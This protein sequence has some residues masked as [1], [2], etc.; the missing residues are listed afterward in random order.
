MRP[1]VGSNVERDAD[2][3]FVLA[4]ALH[5][6]LLNRERVGADFNDLGVEFLELIVVC[7][8]PAHLVQSAACEAGRV[9]SN[10]NFLSSQL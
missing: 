5:P 6:R 7:A 9:E 4:H 3:A 10:Y 2:H 1:E 8:E